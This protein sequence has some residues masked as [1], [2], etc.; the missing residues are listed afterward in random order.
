MI[1]FTPFGAA[2]ATV[3]SVGGTGASVP[4]PF[5]NFSISSENITSGDSTQLNKKYTVSVSGNATVSSSDLQNIRNEGE[6]QSS[7][8][9]KSKT[10]TSVVEGLKEAAGKLAVESRG[11]G[12][13]RMEFGYARLVSAEA[14]EVPEETGGVQYQPYT[15]VFECYDLGGGSTSAFK[16]ERAE[17]NWELSEDE[18]AAY[19][20]SGLA[21][22]DTVEK[23]YK[24]THT[25]TAQGQKKYTNGGMTSDGTAYAQAAIW[26]NAKL[27]DDPISELVTTNAAGDSEFWPDKF[28]AARMD[29]D[30][31]ERVEYKLDTLSYKAYNRVRQVQTDLSSGTYTVTTSWVISNQERNATYTV[32]ANIEDNIESPN[33]SVVINGTFNGLTESKISDKV[34]KDKF[35]NAKAAYQLFKPSALSYAQKVYAD[36]GFTGA[37][38]S[39]PVNLS[40]GENKT[41]GVVTC[42]ITYDDREIEILGAASENINVTHKNRYGIEDVYAVIAIIGKLDG[43]IIQDMNTTNLWKTDV[44]VDVVMKRGY[45]KPDVSAVVT[46][47]RPSGGKCQASS[48]SWNPKTRT[49]NLSETWEAIPETTN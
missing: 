36:A 43:P 10:L 13:G 42:A 18:S 47:Y 22:D 7:L 14:G 37:L 3:L 32:E 5:P 2:G 29:K 31:R 6:R 33:I 8:L 4:G 27:I 28:K 17:E 24:I 41:E 1:I 46:A 44:T 25:L 11:G 38:R 40:Y 26:V 16:L 34:K 45:G 30:G 21:T 15:L 39:E 20:L 12:S 23:V 48:E 35:T 19:I 9:E 49:Y